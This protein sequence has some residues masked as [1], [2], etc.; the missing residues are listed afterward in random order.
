MVATVSLARLDRYKVGRGQYAVPALPAA[1]FDAIRLGVA[2]A[3][4]L[5]GL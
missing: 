4:V 3:L 1:D 2:K 5:T